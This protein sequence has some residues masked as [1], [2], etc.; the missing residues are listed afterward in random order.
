MLKAICNGQVKVFVDICRTIGLPVNLEKTHWGTTLLTF[1]GLLID[2]IN[3]GV[4]VPV[5]KIQKGLKMIHT[6]LSNPSK[7]CTLLQ[8]QK[9]CG[10][11]NFLGRC[12]IPGCAF[13]RRLYAYTVG[14]KHLDGHGNMLVS[15]LKPHR[16]IRING[17]M[18]RD[19][20]MW[21]TFLHQSAFCRPFMDFSRTWNAREVQ[22]YTDASGKIGMGGICGKSWMHQ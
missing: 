6:I 11:L 9:I 2:T 15:Q 10:F 3:R 5:E 16:H 1:L 22:F 20:N 18:R 8:L 13:T 21:T 14:K 17:E 19:L 12:V 7:K 4:S